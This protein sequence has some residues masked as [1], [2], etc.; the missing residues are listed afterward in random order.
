MSE[1]SD[2]EKRKRKVSLGPARLMPELE[3]GHYG[4]YRPVVIEGWDERVGEVVRI[5][6]EEHRPVGPLAV[7]R[8]ARAGEPIHMRSAK[9]D[10]TQLELTCV[11]DPS[12][13][14][15][16]REGDDRPRETKR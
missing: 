5:E 3:R 9:Q 15:F 10:G 7:F 1:P 8:E 14:A 2:E 4:L 6:S 13:Y 16:L 11:W 12:G